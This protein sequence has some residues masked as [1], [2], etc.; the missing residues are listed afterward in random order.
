MW[1]RNIVVDRVARDLNKVRLRAMHLPLLGRKNSVWKVAEVGTGMVGT[2][3]SYKAAMR[4]AE[5]TYAMV[6]LAKSGA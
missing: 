4:T 2:S 5:T 1:Q 6:P 3:S